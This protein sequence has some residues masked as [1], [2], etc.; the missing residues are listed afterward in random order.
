[1]IRAAAP[2][3]TG[4]SALRA[5]G[6]LLSARWGGAVLTG[7]AGPESTPTHRRRPQAHVYQQ[8]GR[9][10]PS[11]RQRRG[12]CGAGSGPGGSASCLPRESGAGVTEGSGAVVPAAGALGAQECCLHGDQQPPHPQGYP[13][14]LRGRDG[15]ARW[16]P[17]CGPLPTFSGSP[18]RV[19]PTETPPAPIPPATPLWSLCQAPR[20][21]LPLPSHS[22]CMPGPPLPLWILWA[23][24]HH[25]RGLHPLASP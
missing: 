16:L 11:N 15:V 3:C 4:P 10:A 23:K 24:D 17:T 20:R 5:G 8:G 19:L 6:W 7:G 12:G 1:M 2:S 9:D 21:T 13:A 14:G 22:G 18:L 25:H